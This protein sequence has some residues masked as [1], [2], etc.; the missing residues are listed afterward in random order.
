MVH[1]QARVELNGRLLLEILHDKFM[2]LNPTV[3]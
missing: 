2:E 1:L 3:K